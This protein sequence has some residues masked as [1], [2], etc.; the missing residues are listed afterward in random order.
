MKKD[1]KFKY[2]YTDGNI[3]DESYVLYPLTNKNLNRIIEAYKSSKSDDL[4]KSQEIDDLYRKIYKFVLDNEADTYLEDE[5]LLEELFEYDED[6]CFDE[7]SIT[8]V[9]NQLKRI[10]DFTIH[11]PEEIK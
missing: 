2:S 5:S 6:L 9:R 8:K 10:Y 7:I 3:G 4:S 11:F 1:Y